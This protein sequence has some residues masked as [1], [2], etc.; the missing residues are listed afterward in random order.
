[1]RIIRVTGQFSGVTALWTRLK[2]QIQQ[3]LLLCASKEGGRHLLRVTPAGMV[4]F[5]VRG[6]DVVNA[7]VEVDGGGFELRVPHHHLDVADIAAI[8]QEG[9]SEGMAEGVA[10][11]LLAEVRLP[12]QY[13]HPQSK[14]IGNQ[15]GA[16][17]ADKKGGAVLGAP[18]TQRE[19]STSVT[20]S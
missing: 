8:V 18:K 9:G 20:F 14:T 7:Q 16:V 6:P 11:A 12:N 10:T 4:K 5:F 13:A 19:K 3:Q 1:M 17:G 15:P 2:L